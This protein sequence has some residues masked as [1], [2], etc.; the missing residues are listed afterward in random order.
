MPLPTSSP[1]GSATTSP[2]TPDRVMQL[3]WGF[4]GPE[5][6]NSALD[7]QLFGHVAKGAQTVEALVSA[8]G[9]SQRGMAML[10][11][12]L[13][14]FGLL[15]REGP[16]EKAKY[17][18]AADADLFLVPGKPSYVGGFI[19]FHA[20]FI[21]KNWHQLTE[22]VKSGRPV[23][24][25][26]TPEKGV[27]VWHLLV[28]ALFNVGF[29]G[30]QGLAQEILKS[31]RQRPLQVLDV[32]CGSGVWGIAQCLAE[33]TTRATFFDLKE[34]LEHTRRFVATHEIGARADYLEGDLRQT[35]P[36]AGRFDV[37]ILGH[38][39]HSEGAE[40]T[41]RL[42]AKMARA[43]KRGGTLAIAEFLPDDD[44]LAP[45]LGLIFALN[46]LVMTSEGA[47]FTFAEYRRWLESAGFKDVR[48]LPG[49]TV[50]PLILATR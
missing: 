26:D 49:P 38:I 9:A 24:A 46:M 37:A 11:D 5:I 19:Q 6:L 31:N 43:L 28:D 15:L 40:H 16:R 10:V 47:T 2:P 18:N 42:F 4:A 20:G 35:E 12:G 41:Q 14:A 34:T 22:C 39:C 3:A 13:A 17:R 1:A 21:A 29:P 48:Q 45:P 30:A 27:P 7:L 36:P 8:T 32:A 25:A 33:P 50:S 44:R 23:F